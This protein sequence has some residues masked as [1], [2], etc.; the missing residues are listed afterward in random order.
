MKTLLLSIL[1]IFNTAAIAADDADLYAEDD[2]IEEETYQTKINEQ[3]TK[4][5]QKQYLNQAINLIK[6]KEY[7]QARE[8]LFQIEKYKN[9]ETYY[10]IGLI[11]NKGYGIGKDDKE[12]AKYF[13]RAAQ[14]GHLQSQFTIAYMY[15]NG[16]GANLSGKDAAEWYQKAAEQGMKK[17]QLKMG[18]LYYDGI[19]VKRDL[20]KAAKWY[21]KVAD[22]GDLIAEKLYQKVMFDLKKGRVY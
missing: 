17:A 14:L 5:Q 10:Q 20:K 3:L 4:T 19:G 8:I 2:I 11:F 6:K 7:I 9:A 13:L 15:E 16:I 22:T 1:L 18:D 21:K 12:S